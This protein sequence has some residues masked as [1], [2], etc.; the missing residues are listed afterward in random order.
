MNTILVVDVGLKGAAFVGRANIN[1]PEAVCAPYIWNCRTRRQYEKEKEHLHNHLRY[2]AKEWHCGYLAMEEPVSIMGRRKVG[3]SQ[4]WLGAQISLAVGLPLIQVPGQ[5]AD[6]GA[7]AWG[8]MRNSFREIMSA[9]EWR[10]IG[11]NEHVHDAAA[12]FLAS[13]TRIKNEVRNELSAMP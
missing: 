13:L 11:E 1:G 6:A 12:I 7:K 3:V 5:K 9:E 4:A 2:M 8:V 10:E